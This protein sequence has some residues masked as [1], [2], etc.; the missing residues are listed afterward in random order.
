M[1]PSRG[2]VHPVLV[3]THEEGG[4]EFSVYLSSTESVI[5][6]PELYLLVCGIAMVLLC[7]I[8]WWRFPI[9]K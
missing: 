8:V 9:R 5:V 4:T 2:L 3:L 1:D 7:S 6:F